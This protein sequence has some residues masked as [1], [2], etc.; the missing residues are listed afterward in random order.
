[1]AFTMVDVLSIDV[2]KSARIKTAKTALDKRVVQSVSV[3]E[4]PVENFIRN[5]E[6]VLSTA[7]GCGNDSHIFKKFVQD[8]F[9]S[10]AAALA[11]AT[12]RHVSNI[13]KDILDFAEENE[14]PIIEIPWEVRFADIIQAI[15]GKLYNWHQEK[16]RR[17][18]D[19]QKQ[20]LHLFLNDGS[21]S[22]AAKA[23]QKEI[24]YPVIIISKDG[25]IKGRSQ[26]SGILVEKWN[27]YL[28][29]GHQTYN[30]YTQDFKHFQP[31]DG[32]L[33]PLVIQSSSKI[34]GYIILS[35]SPEISIDSLLNL[36]ENHVLEQ[37]LPAIV[38][39]FQRES[40]IQDT[41]MRL[42][43]DFIWSL[44]KGEIE[45]WDSAL[46]RA[47]SLNYAISLP[48]V[49][50]LG[51]PENLESIFQKK[52]ADDLS[53]EHWLHNTIHSI[54]EQ[55]NQ[56]GTSIQRKTM[57]TYQLDRFVIFLEISP[58]QIS[59][60]VQNFLDVLENRLCQVLP[61]LILSWGVG[62]NHAGIKT[63]HESFND[64]RIALEVGYHQKGPG[65]RSTYANTEM[66]RVLLSLAKNSE[67]QEL[68][69]STIGALIDYDNQRGL[70]LVN[71]FVTY[72]QNQGNVSQTSRALN[73]HRQSLLYRLKKIETLTGRT[74]VDPDD[75]FLLNLCIK[76]WIT[77]MTNKK[78]L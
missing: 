48:Y 7:I 1:M 69:L 29:N 53:Y 70:E 71:T 8:V 26:N 11:I 21:L 10:G 50:I 4:I 27:R 74:L 54:K 5:N 46:S 60:N 49:C 34:F 43:D 39:W 22:D 33:I 17:S 52:K 58:D 42:R 37:A 15:L 57:T 65:H 38:L 18:E 77:D 59:K 9:S 13:P 36:E 23:I 31:L 78:R 40:A 55:I 64:A 12:G 56:T 75:L 68:T 45:S 61:G 67:I 30:L 3:I 25:L 24:G 44:A 19:L 14:F 66:Y 32:S 41:E 47:R 35:I 2:M 63:F 20:L 73:L 62:E 72:I 6:L 51:L 76:I 16:L 28:Q